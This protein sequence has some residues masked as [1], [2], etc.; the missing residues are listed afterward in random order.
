MQTSTGKLEVGRDVRVLFRKLVD[1]V[2]LTD[3][4][5]KDWIIKMIGFEFVKH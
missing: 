3:Q 4:E 2:G 1:E 5:A